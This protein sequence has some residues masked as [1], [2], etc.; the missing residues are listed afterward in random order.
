[1]TPPTPAMSVA[2]AALALLALCSA[3][4]ADLRALFDFSA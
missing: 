1:M 4:R 3:A 2:R